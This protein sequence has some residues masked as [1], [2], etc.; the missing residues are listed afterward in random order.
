MD[1]I[2]AVILNTKIK[3]LETFNNKR[4]EVARYY[5]KELSEIEDIVT[6]RVEEGNPV[7][8]Q[9]AICCSYKDE[10]GDFLASRSVGSAAFYPVPLHL[11]KAFSYL[12]YREGDLPIAESLSKR[13]VCLPI[14]PELMREE[15]DYVIECI[16][17]FYYQH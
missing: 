9:Y 13:T 3:Y 12:N 6:P 10:L 17:E 1:A 16:K 5:N 14:Y 8:H 15:Q 7:W 4:A 2:Q 11:Q